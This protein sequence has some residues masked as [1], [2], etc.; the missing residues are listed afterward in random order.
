[1]EALHTNLMPS[2]TGSGV[3]AAIVPRP[4]TFSITPAAAAAIRRQLEK[5]GTPNSSL[6]VGIRGGGCSGYSYV[7]EFHDGDPQ[8]HDRVFELEG[9]HVVIDP[10]SLVYLTGSKLDWESTL[11]Q[12]GF[13]FV[14]PNEASNCGC[15]HSFTV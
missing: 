8:P 7:I 14:N 9:V 1:M 6:R 10:K 15:G 4:T 3:L 13:K 12:R 5:R 2:M 11:M